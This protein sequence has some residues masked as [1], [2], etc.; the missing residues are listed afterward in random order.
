MRAISSYTVMRTGMRM[1]R[2]VERGG[3]RQAWIMAIITGAVMY[4]GAMG[5]CLVIRQ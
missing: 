3:D 1:G 4:L 2:R 5:V